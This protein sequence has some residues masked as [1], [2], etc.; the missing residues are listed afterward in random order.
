MLKL[1]CLRVV[2]VFYPTGT[3][4]HKKSK[5]CCFLGLP[6]VGP[7]HYDG[8]SEVRQ[9]SRILEIHYLCDA[10]KCPLDPEEDLR[11]V[12]R[13]EI[14]AAPNSAGPGST[15][16]DEDHLEE[17]QDILEH[18]EEC[19]EDPLDEEVYQRLSFDLCD[20]CRKN[21]LRDPLGRRLSKQLSFSNN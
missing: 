9:Y 10:C 8:A 15:T 12:V 6:R 18:F 13:M 17:I 11:Y 16:D 19:E 14:Y 20:A 7:S 5:L 2:L 1:T 4:S 3:L 21:F